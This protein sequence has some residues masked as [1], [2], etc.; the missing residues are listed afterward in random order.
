MR[1]LGLEAAGFFG[2]GGGGICRAGRNF[3]LYRASL[4]GPAKHL[5]F[6]AL[7]VED[8]GFFGI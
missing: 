2:S 1:F 3:D 8:D 5:A 6:E 7:E 4:G